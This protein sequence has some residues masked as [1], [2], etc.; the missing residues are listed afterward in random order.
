MGLRHDVHVA[1][2]VVGEI[3]VDGFGEVEVLQL[4]EGLER[5]R[6]EDVNAENLRQA[7]VVHVEGIRGGELPVAVGIV[8]ARVFHHVYVFRWPSCCYV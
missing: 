5:W 8:G 4:R 2:E 7:V 1:P 3:I 6:C